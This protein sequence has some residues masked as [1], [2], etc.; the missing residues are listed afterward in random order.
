MKKLQTLQAN[1]GRPLP[2]RERVLAAAADLFYNG[3]IRATGVEA[4]AAHAGTTK[5]ALYRHYQSKDALVVEWLRQVTGEYWAAFDAIESAHTDNPRAQ[6]LG[7]ADLVAVQVA[8]WS[9]RGCPFINSIAELPNR[10]HPARR[11][12]EEHKARQWKRLVGLS[13]AAGLVAP[14]DTASEIMFV[15]EGAQIAA[16]NMSI[17]HIGSRLRRVVEGI[18]VRQSTRSSTRIESQ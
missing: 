12:I 13:K 17:G 14:E 16:Q 3:G 2:P 7:W 10:D 9:H 15:L 8:A 11:L 6:I 18:V 5:M 1:A 4:I